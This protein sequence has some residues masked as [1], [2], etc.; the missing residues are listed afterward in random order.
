MRLEL[1]VGKG[2]EKG[3]RNSA[4]QVEQK[5]VRQMKHLVENFNKGGW[6]GSGVGGGPVCGDVIGGKSVHNTFKTPTVC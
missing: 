4:M 2:S 3:E 6:G 5:S 1:V